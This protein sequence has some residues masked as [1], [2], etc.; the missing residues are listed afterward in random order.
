VASS[1]A[2]H[3][4]CDVRRIA[5][6]SNAVDC[7][8][9]TPGLL[10]AAQRAHARG[11]LVFVVTHVVR[12]QL[13]A[14]KDV[15]RRALLLRVWA[16]MPK[17]LVPTHGAAWQGSRWGESTW[18]DGEDSGVTLAEVRTQGRGAMQDAVIATTA[19][20][21]AD[22]LVTGDVRLREQVRQSTARCEVWS[23]EQL[24]DFIRA[25]SDSSSAPTP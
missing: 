14:T 16:A 12:E 6:D 4:S 22:V 23:F 21:E 3:P 13:A 20:G 11:A 15:A 18:G 8:A 5:L 2:S 19:A 17:V 1:E 10:D 24:R 25:A 9:D 7:L